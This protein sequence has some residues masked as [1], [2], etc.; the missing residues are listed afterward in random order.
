M[1]VFASTLLPNFGVGVVSIAVLTYGVSITATMS[2]LGAGVGVLFGHTRQRS[3]TLH[4]ATQVVAGLAVV[5][6][7]A[8]LLVDAVPLLV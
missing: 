1:I 8:S 5:A 2:L 3:M 4:G 6:L 7:A